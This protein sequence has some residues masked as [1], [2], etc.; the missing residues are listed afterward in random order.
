MMSGL[1]DTK[2]NSTSQSSVDGNQGSEPTRVEYLALDEIRKD[3]GTQP[4]ATIDLKHVLLLEEQMEDGQQLEPV[5]V[6]YDG[7]SYWLADGFH[8]FCAHRNRAS[9]AIAG[10]CPEVPDPGTSPRISDSGQPGGA[11]LGHPARR[12]D[13]LYY[14][15]RYKA[16]CSSLLGGRECR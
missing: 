8:R 15:P 6:F 2:A 9:V 13:R 4:R 10:L 14:L 1:F 5:V 16:G 12:S 11:W 3:G 7:E